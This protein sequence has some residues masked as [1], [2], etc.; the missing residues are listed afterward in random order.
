M[1]FLGKATG[2]FSIKDSNINIGSLFTIEDT[3][4]I[5][6][7]KPTDVPNM[8]TY[9]SR[10][11]IL[12]KEDYVDETILYKYFD[13]LKTIFSEEPHINH[14]SLDEYILM[15]IMRHDF[16][17]IIIEQQAR[18]LNNKK[19]DFLLTWEGRQVYIEFDGPQHFIGKDSLEDPFTRSKQ[20]EDETGVEVVRWPYW[21]QR[22]SQNLHVVF[23]KTQKGYG[24]LW[25][26]NAMFGDFTIENAG[27]VIRKMNERF[28]AADENGIGYFY[29]KNMHGRIQPEHPIIKKILQGK[30]SRDKLIPKGCHDINYWL[31]DALRQ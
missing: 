9:L 26:S 7:I 25:S 31:P 5:L 21:I 24:A 1:S 23:D 3:L 10:L 16:P 29:E 11:K 19:A 20:I 2:I 13:V 12:N 22:C 15:G 17:G 14:V 18:V 8:K 4:D 28:N 27:N 6:G 30:E